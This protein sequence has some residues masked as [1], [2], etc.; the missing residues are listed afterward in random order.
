MTRPSASAVV[1][2]DRWAER[3]AL[4]VLAALP[5]AVVVVD[6]ED[7]VRD[8]NP[9]AEELLGLSASQLAGQ[10]LAEAVRADGPLFALVARAR[11]SGAAVSEYGVPMSLRR[12]GAFL[13]DL[14]MAPIAEAPGAVAIVLRERT[15]ADKL[16]G[17][18]AQQAA[19]RALATLAMTLAHEIKNPLS[20]IRGAAQLLEPDQGEGG[21]SLARLIVGE[22]DRI[23]GLVDRL[24]TFADER[25]AARRALNVHEVLEH[26]RRLVQ[27]GAGPGVRFVQRYDPSLPDVE[28][29]RD[30]LV[31]A[32]LNLA[33]NAV[34]A[35]TAAGGTAGEIVLTTAYETGL[36]LVPAGGS[37]RVDLPIVVTVQDDGPG[38]SEAVGPHL[39]EPFVT[40]K[41][42]GR[43][44][45]LPVVAKVVAAHGGAIEVESRPG[46]TLFRV[47]LPVARG[48]RKRP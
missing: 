38:V 19:G 47:F 22:V 11:T 37:A 31:Q 27:A 9:A 13:A 10:P 40:G 48:R 26:V 12:G 43:G 15:M 14:R 24:E 5:D 45:G 28:G 46:R 34:E 39:F 29:D 21:K 35:V 44:L 18:I 30:Q 6:A 7:R 2:P 25:P 20:G 16:G 4:A 3:Q 36:R 1:A 23:R 41:P 33:K 8:A 32:F 42:G 17:Q